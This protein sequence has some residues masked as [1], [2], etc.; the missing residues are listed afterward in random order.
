MAEPVWPPR[1][2]KMYTSSLVSQCHLPLANQSG[3]SLARWLFSCSR[4][5]SARAMNHQKVFSKL[6]VMLVS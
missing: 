4:D 2:G 5:R 6:G 3:E 1:S